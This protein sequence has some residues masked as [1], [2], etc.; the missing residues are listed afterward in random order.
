MDVETAFL[1]GTLDYEIYMEQPKGFQDPNKPDHVCRLKK[2]L[3]GLKQSARCWNATLDDYLLSEGYTKSDADDCIYVKLIRSNDIEHFV[4]LAVY[5]DD[6]VPISDDVGILA[7]EKAKLK[8]RFVMVDNGE[9]DYLLGLLIK[10]DRNE[11]KLSISQPCYLEN[12]LERFNMTSCNPVATPME[13]GRKFSKLSDDE[14]PF[15][16]IQLYQQAVGCLMYAATATRPDIASAIGILAQY[17]SAPSMNHWSG[18]K[19]I[20]RLKS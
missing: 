2:S 9:I 15:S 4:I 10:R 17:M 3:Y 19:R 6:V 18:I 13:T 8:E 11:R 12:I 7:S 20:L 16:D 5:V 1:N 14:A